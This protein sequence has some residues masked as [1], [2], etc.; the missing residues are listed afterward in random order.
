MHCNVNYKVLPLKYGLD[1]WIDLLHRT[2]KKTIS[3]CRKPK[4][5][6]I[7]SL[8]QSNGFLPTDIGARMQRSNGTSSLV[9]PVR[10]VEIER[11][12]W[13]QRFQIYLNRTFC[14]LR[15]QIVQL[16]CKSGRRYRRPTDIRVYCRLSSITL[17]L[18]FSWNVKIFYLLLE[19]SHFHMF[20]QDLRHQLV[21]INSRIFEMLSLPK[22]KKGEKRWKFSFLVI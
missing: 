14:W 1:F 21:W 19:L 16:L 17:T 4:V 13:F 22:R 6:W 8:Q 3:V 7:F 11:S 18:H 2:G 9:S 15:R 12:L 5:F 20:Y 10:N